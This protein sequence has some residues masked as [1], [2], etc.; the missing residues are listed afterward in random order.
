MQRESAVV[1]GGGIVGCAATL[2]LSRQGFD[3][4]L[5]EP[6]P[7]REFKGSFG[8]DPRTVALSPST[9][10]WLREL[11]PEFDVP[12][13]PIVS[14]RVWEKTGTGVIEFDAEEVGASQLAYVFE[15]AALATALWR[16]AT[17][18]ARGLM[19]QPIE[20]LG[21]DSGSVGLADGRTVAP[22]IVVVAEGSASSTRDLTGV[23][24]C[25]LGPRGTAIATVVQSDRPHNGVAFQRF[26]EGILAFLPMHH[27]R[28]MSVIWSVSNEVATGL[29][30]LNEPEFLDRLN[31]ESERACGELLRV[32]Q[33]KSFPV[34]QEVVKNFVPVPRIVLVG[35]AARTVHPLAGFGVNLGIEDVRSL[36]R[37]IVETDSQRGLQHALAQFAVR[38]QLR[39]QMMVALMFS[40]ANVWSWS[41]GYPIWI[42]NLGM[43]S[44]NKSSLLKQQVIREA[45][46]NSALTQFI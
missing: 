31:K 25:T 41:G 34:F 36:E 46:G 12:C 9:A 32:D 6:A 11:L 29:L 1:S 21:Q 27:D 28:V 14:M 7:P 4:D 24:R 5:I 17:Q 33:R 43:R 23:G 35:D 44:F 37:A 10:A 20:K 16:H 8:V 45:T 3:V 39:S 2:A 42:R 38:R 13:Q 40:L 22:S 26:S 15:H 19:V 18:K 30:E